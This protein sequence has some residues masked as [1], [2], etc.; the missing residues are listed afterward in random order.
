MGWLFAVSAGELESEDYSPF[1]CE[2]RRGDC[3][4]VL[5]VADALVSHGVGLDVINDA[6]HGIERVFAL[7]LRAD[8]VD[9]DMLLRAEVSTDI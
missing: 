3:A 8:D 5:D 4:H 2:H 6:L 9:Q 1:F 7:V